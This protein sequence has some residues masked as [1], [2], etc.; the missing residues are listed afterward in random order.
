[1][2]Q[3][4]PNTTLQTRLRSHPFERNGE[5]YEVFVKLRDLPQNTMLVDAQYLIP[6]AIRLTDAQLNAVSDRLTKVLID[7][8]TLDEFGNPIGQYVAWKDQVP[9][10]ATE[11]EEVEVYHLFMGETGEDDD[12]ANWRELIPPVLLQ[13]IKDSTIPQVVNFRQKVVADGRLSRAE[14]KT[15]FTWL[16]QNGHVS[17][18][19]AKA[20]IRR[21]RS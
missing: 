10:G 1:M 15:A 17:V 19:R 8:P 7:D 14:V 21:I 11:L 2:L 18:Q 9:P 12:T 4:I 5:R 16:V 6:T 20:I 13:W 3:I